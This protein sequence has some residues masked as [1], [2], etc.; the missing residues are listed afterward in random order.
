VGQGIVGFCAQVGVSLAVS[1]VQK[2]PHFMASISEKIGYECRTMICSPL[3]KDGRL[4]GAVQ[5]INR[6]GGTMFLPEEL[7][8]LN[9]LAHE[10]ALLL[11]SVE[12]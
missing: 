9:Y 11:S 8:V 3:Y 2:D 4:W 6:G 7:D 1:D 10:G 12:D 5:L